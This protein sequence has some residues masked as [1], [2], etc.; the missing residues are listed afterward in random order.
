VGIS[1]CDSKVEVTAAK[2][3]DG[4]V[5]VVVLNSGLEDQGYAI[6]VQ[7][8]VARVKIPAQT[9]STIILDLA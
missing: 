9:I 2:N 7:G 3:P 4:S 1:K 8:R 5:A 6:R